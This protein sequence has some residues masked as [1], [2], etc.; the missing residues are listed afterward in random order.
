MN[1]NQ[2]SPN[3]NA[4][5]DDENI[6]EYHRPL[7]PANETTCLIQN[8]NS[9][10]NNPNASKFQIFKGIFYAFL[11]AILFS[12]CALIIKYLQEISPSELS[13]AMLSGM[14]L[15]SLPEICYK[16]LNPFGT[17]DVR[18]FLMM[19]GVTY[20]LSLV[21]RFYCIHFMPIAEASVI[22]FSFP[23]VVTIFAKV[24]LKVSYFFILK[25]LNLFL[26]VQN[27]FSHISIIFKFLSNFV[28]YILSQTKS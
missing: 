27:V 15:L 8:G 16:Q 19:R 14:T 25:I 4:I 20:G 13:I 1:V 7:I 23:I 2:E 9:I 21:L 22:I 3:I 11:S 12:S 5:R 28:D 10:N 6:I 18:S 26:K 24:F 17:R